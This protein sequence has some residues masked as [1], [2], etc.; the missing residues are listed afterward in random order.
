[1]ADEK[2]YVSHAGIEQV[3]AHSKAEADAER[4][5]SQTLDD[6]KKVTTVDTLHNDEAV[7]VLAAYAGDEHWTP[8]EEKRVVRKIDRRLLPLLILTYGLQYY[9]KAM[10]SQAAIFGLRTD[11]ELTGNRYSFSASIFYLGF[12]VGAT[13][14]IIMAQ[15]FP[16]ER[17]AFAIVGIWGAAMMCTAAVGTFKGLYAQRFFLGMLESG[18]SPMFMLI[19][20]GFYRKDEQALRMGAW[21][22]ATGYVSIFAPLS[23]FT[24]GSLYV[25]TDTN[26]QSIT[27]SAT[28]KEH[29]LPGNTCTSLQGQSQSSGRSS[30]CST[31]P[32]IRFE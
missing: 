7:K 10:L 5:T 21:Y 6:L 16:I 9:D 28:S 30:F 17:V 32:Q 4:R 26:A 27:V 20:A 23:M 15:R 25:C 24:S 31:C 22:C 14:A 13:P 2:A 3:P 18:V 29:C 11:L 1:M 12:I 19:V 8:E